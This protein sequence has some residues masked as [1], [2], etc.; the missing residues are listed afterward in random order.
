MIA[1]DQHQLIPERRH[2]GIVQVVEGEQNDAIHPRRSSTARCSCTLAG[3]N[4]LSISTA[5]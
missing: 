5:S 3:E 1:G 4:L 2:G